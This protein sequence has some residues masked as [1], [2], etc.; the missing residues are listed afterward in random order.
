LG[1]VAA[2]RARRYDAD[3]IRYVLA[4]TLPETSDSNFTW[5]GFVRH[6]NNELVATWGNLVNRVLTFATK[7]WN[8][9]VPEP[10]SYREVDQALLGQIEGGFETV[11]ALLEAVKLRGALGEA[12]G[13]ARAV[14]GYLEQAPWYGV[15]RKDREAAATTVY[16][17]LLAIDSLKVLLAPFVPFSSEKLHGILGY[18][19]PLFGRQEIGRY[20]EADRSHEALVYDGSGASGRWEPSR[21]TPGQRLELP[22]ALF[23]KLDEVIVV[24]EQGRLVLD[25]V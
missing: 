23:R 12:L 9:R 11:G 3:A 20:D 19:R 14:N 10:G 5:A 8:G 24:E 21:L 1:G 13:L 22:V 18:E 7:H 6:N 2:G 25:A 4:A 15:I 17:A 16:T